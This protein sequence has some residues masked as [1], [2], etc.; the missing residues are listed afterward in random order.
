MCHTDQDDYR[1]RGAS[2]DVVTSKMK[3]G[4][5]DVE[6]FETKCVMISDEALGRRYFGHL[7]M[8]SCGIEQ[9]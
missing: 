5:Q 6:F 7:E 3:N 2:R 4:L 1:C 8:H 9:D